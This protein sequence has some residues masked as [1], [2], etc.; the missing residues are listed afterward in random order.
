[1]TSYEAQYL[2]GEITIN[3]FVIWLIGIGADPDLVT[4]LADV[5]SL[6]AFLAGRPA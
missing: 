2:R 5:A 6:K 3:E 1:M 4:Y